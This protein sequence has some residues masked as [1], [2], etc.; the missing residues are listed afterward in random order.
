MKITI[1]SLTRG[2]GRLGTPFFLFSLLMMPSERLAMAAEEG[3]TG[4]VSPEMLQRSP[5]NA[6]KSS[7]G[8]VVVNGFTFSGNTLLGAAELQATVKEYVGRRCT[9]G[10]LRQAAGKVSAEYLRRGNPL[11]TAYIPPQK[12][13]GGIVEVAIVEGRIGR[14]II[15]G[16]KNY[17][18]DFIRRNIIGTN[19]GSRPTYD[20]I[21]N[22]LLRL[23]EDFADLKLTANFA[24]GDAPGTTDVHIKVSDSRPGHLTLSANNFGSKYVSRY[25]FGATAD[26]SNAVID[27]S[28]L[29][30]GGIVGDHADRMK[31]Y[32]GSYEF[33]VNDSGTTIGMSA[34]HGNF[35]VGNDLADLGI[36]NQESSA[37]I[38]LRRPL[39]RRRGEKLFGKLGFRAA[40]A[41]YYQ[42]DELSSLDNTRVAYLQLQG[43][44]VFAGGR[45]LAN[46]TVS[47]G[48][49]GVFGGTETG[50][51]N[52]SRSGA[53]NDFFKT[54]LDLV[55]LQPISDLFSSVV[56]L[57]GQWSPDNLLASEEWLV[58][59]QE[60]VHGFAIG[61][62]AGDS[63]YS[64]SFSLRVNPLEN[65]EFLQLAAFLDYGHSYKRTIFSGSRHSTDL[66]G[67]G[68]GVSSHLVT[69][70]PTDLR[71]DVGFPLNPST[72]QSKDKVAFYFQTS[73]RL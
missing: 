23:N 11:A 8:A 26:W 7:D 48:L 22:G 71:F 57:S 33:P 72:N 42:L 39:V 56:R 50:S 24:P 69:I 34:F 51:A 70:A 17:S 38:Y 65:R 32:S 41:K 13:A 59:G 67:I 1:A 44:R 45:G 15:E 66:T 10:D 47:K 64:A 61:E 14:V 37:D 49:G 35:D 18:T 73:I 2:A 5:V 54:N 62:A 27:G 16:N 21:E 63:G 19:A 28:Y 30:L 40:E 43:D 60:S 58:G 53:D 36:H 6:E 20:R 52:T 9:L 31:V 68:L 55:R 29:A 4:G 46:L 25:R 12:V 3:S